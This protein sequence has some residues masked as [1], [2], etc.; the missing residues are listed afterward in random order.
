MLKLGVR[1]AILLQPRPNSVSHESNLII[2]GG[3]AIVIDARNANRFLP[4]VEQLSLLEVGS[5]VERKRIP[6]RLELHFGVSDVIIPGDARLRLGTG[7]HE[8]ELI[9]YLALRA[10]VVIR[11]VDFVKV[12]ISVAEST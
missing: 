11:A 3:Q 4:V 6:I 12:C 7:L 5:W 10:L 9:L 1:E 2:S 8:R